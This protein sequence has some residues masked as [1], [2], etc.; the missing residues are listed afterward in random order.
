MPR[1]RCKVELVDI[2]DGEIMFIV[3]SETIFNHWYEVFVNRNGQVS[4]DCMDSVCRTKRPHFVDLLNGTNQHCC[5]H[6]KS[7]AKAMKKLD[8]C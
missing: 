3:Q 4:C 6:M 2:L 1:S 5:K 7:I 8:K